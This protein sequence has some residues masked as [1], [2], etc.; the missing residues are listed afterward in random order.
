MPI[1]DLAKK[2]EYQN[3]WMRK[4]REA[5]LEGKSCQW[6]KATAE[7]Q[8]VR[9]LPE[10]TPKA[11]SVFSRRP[12]V[13]GKLLRHTVILCRDCYLKRRREQRPKQHGLTLYAEGCRCEVCMA[14]VYFEHKR[15]RER[16]R[17]KLAALRKEVVKAGGLF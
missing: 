17:A 7:L 13:H 14:A 2:R 8:V 6:C 15:Y 4:R 9:L 5:F 12:G 1:K 10:K 3:T 16:R 11:S